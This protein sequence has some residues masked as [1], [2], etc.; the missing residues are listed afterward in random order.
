MLQQATKKQIYDTLICDDILVSLRNIAPADLII[1]SD[2]INYFG[3][4]NELMSTVYNALLSD[5]HWI[6]STETPTK[7]GE[8]LQ[9]SGRFCHHP[10]I[11]MTAKE[12]VF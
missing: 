8:G 10:N 3:D 11:V 6:F 7:H 5:G 12:R 2:V 9:P 1:A 4:L